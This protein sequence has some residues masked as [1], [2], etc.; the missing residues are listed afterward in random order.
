MAT[1]STGT[2]SQFRPALFCGRQLLTDVSAQNVSPFLT[3]KSV[4]SYKPI[5][6]NIAGK[7]KN[8]HSLPIYRHCIIIQRLMNEQNIVHY[9]WTGIQLILMEVTA[10]TLLYRLY[11]R[12]IALQSTT[13]QHLSL[14]NVTHTCFGPSIIFREISNEG[15]K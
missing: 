14:C 10:K 11:I 6:R 13:N 5:P 15:V 1:S 7:V 8:C 4:I 2:S 9:T 12:Y 3:V